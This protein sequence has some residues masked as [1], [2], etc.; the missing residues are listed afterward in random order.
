[1]LTANISQALRVPGGGKRVPTLRADVYSTMCYVSSI[2]LNETVMIAIASPVIVR[3]RAFHKETHWKS[4]DFRY[5][6][7]TYKV[8]DEL[9]IKRN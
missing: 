2:T 3:P 4:S 1:M 8:G 6:P 9:V 7:H 5:A